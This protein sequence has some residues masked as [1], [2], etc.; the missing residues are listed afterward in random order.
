MFAMSVPDPAEA[1]ARPPTPGFGLSDDVKGVAR[2]A[3]DLE[4]IDEGLVVRERPESGGLL[5]DGSEIA[6]N[7]TT[8]EP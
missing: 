1:T 7:P 5:D 2:R 4:A 6:H 8:R 3:F